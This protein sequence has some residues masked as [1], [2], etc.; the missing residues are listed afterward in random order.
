MGLLDHIVVLG[1]IFGVNSTLFLIM[2]APFCN[3][4]SSA[5]ELSFLNGHL[6]MVSHALGLDTAFSR[7]FFKLNILQ[8]A[9]HEDGH[10]SV[11]FSE[12]K[13]QRGGM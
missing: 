13:N 7:L 8:V 6:T 4:I 2:G 9:L 12:G 11:D 10:F 3:P 1:L 5:Q